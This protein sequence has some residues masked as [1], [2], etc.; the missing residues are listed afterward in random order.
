M[1]RKMQLNALTRH[2]PGCVQVGIAYADRRDLDDGGTLGR[3]SMIMS[4]CLDLRLRM[5]REVLVS[6]LTSEGFF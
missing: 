3:M 5:T 1:I 4:K 6:V 2:W